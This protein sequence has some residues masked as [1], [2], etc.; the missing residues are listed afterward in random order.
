[1]KTL[2]TIATVFLL[3]CSALKTT[4]RR[5]ASFNAQENVQDIAYFNTIKEA[6]DAFKISSTQMKRY[7]N[8]FKSSKPYKFNLEIKYN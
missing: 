5:S 7:L 3:G 1:M 8:G 6:R 2:I 4:D